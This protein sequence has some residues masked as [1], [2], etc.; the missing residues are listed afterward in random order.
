MRLATIDHQEV[1]IK[2]TAAKGQWYRGQGHSQGHPVMTEKLLWVRQLLKQWGNFS[3]ISA[4]VG[5]Q[6]ARVLK[7]VGSNVNVTQD[8]LQKCSSGIDIDVLLV[9]NF[10][11]NEVKG[12]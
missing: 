4:T 3:Q 10:E 8:I 5:S 11:H 9:V 7:V 1:R 12:H 2:P 6:N